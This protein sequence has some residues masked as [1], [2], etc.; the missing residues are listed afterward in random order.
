MR[1]GWRTRKLD[2]ISKSN[3]KSDKRDART[4]AQLVRADASL[5]S[6]IEHG[7]EEVQM[8]LTLLHMRDNLVAARTR[9]ISSI[10]G[11]VKASGE[12]LPESVSATF[13]QEVGTAV[14]EGLRPAVAPLLEVIDKLNEEIFRY[15]LHG[16]TLGADKVS[17]ERAIETGERGGDAERGGIPA[18]GG[19]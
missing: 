13:P 18:D 1:C 7:A 19:R 16:G 5:L 11:V 14:P 15:D 10:R 6:P 12:R 2:L 17:G 8:D 4:L 9:L 3:A